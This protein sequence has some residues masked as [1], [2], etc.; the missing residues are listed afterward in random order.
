MAHLVASSAGK[1]R[2]ERI[3]RVEH[4]PETFMAAIGVLNIAEASGM[5]SKISSSSVS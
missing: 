3:H 2:T 4:R 1:D 5:G